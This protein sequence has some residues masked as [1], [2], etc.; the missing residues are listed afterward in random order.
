[1]ED[2][3]TSS[4]EDRGNEGTEM[5]M[6]TEVVRKMVGGLKIDEIGKRIMKRK[7]RVVMKR[8]RNIKDELVSHG[9]FMEKFEDEKPE[10][11]CR[12]EGK[13]KHVAKKGKDWEC[14]QKEIF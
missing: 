9:K 13:R 6:V 11:V 12:R 7:V 14:E 2:T 5:K 4:S 10:C 3:K 1:M 8:G